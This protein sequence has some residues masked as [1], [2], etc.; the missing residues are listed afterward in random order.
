MKL[1]SQAI[2]LLGRNRLVSELIR[3]G[4]EIAFPIRDRGIDLIVYADRSSSHHEFR[5]IPIQMKGA[6]KKSFSIDKKYEK[7]PRLL[8]AYV[9]G[10]GNDAHE[11]FVL[12]YSEVLK[13]ATDM[14]YTKTDSWITDENYAVPTPGKKLESKLREF[15]M[16][17]EKW[18]AK[19]HVK[20][21][22]DKHQ[23]LL[24][25]GI[26]RRNA[27]VPQDYHPIGQ[28]CSGAYESEYV[29]PYTK[30]AKNANATVA[31][32]LQD[33]SSH[34]SLMENFD[35]DVQ[36]LGYTPA[37][38]TN[39]NLIQLLKTHFELTLDETFATNL[40]PFI[41]PGGMT[42]NIPV[43]LMSSAAK[44]FAMPQILVVRPKLLICLGISVFNTLRRFHGLRQVA[45]L[46][47]G[48]S[49]PFFDNHTWYWCQ[50]HPG[51]LGFINR[52]HRGGQGSVA[53]DWAKMAA[54]YRDSFNSLPNCDEPQNKPA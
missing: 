13:I 28:Y 39:V 16:T 3:A 54:N 52:E 46:E 27:S 11:T 49:Q 44:E 26:K 48:I 1:D 41:K 43:K 51:A 10:I 35:P 15:Q 24:K 31:I 20:V 7:I 23:Q 38:P 30:S 34:D 45:N 21:E 22:T 12:T 47:Q 19:L 9:W 36:R 6:S 17:P 50:A 2:E 18:C 32:M 29:S 8:I 4:L 42:T 40:F 53:R 5:A 37:S 33:W 25:I 14:G